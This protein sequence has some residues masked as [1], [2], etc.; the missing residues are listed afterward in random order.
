MLEQI[1]KRGR[2]ISE[3]EDKLEEFRKIRE[4]IAKITKRD[5]QS[6]EDFN[7]YVDSLGPCEVCKYCTGVRNVVSVQERKDTETKKP[8]M[9]IL[10]QNH[11]ILSI[12]S[13]HNPALPAFCCIS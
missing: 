7:S 2:T 6:Q 9:I 11:L 8:V 1:N 5:E 4:R 3:R 10:Y 13:W 12:P